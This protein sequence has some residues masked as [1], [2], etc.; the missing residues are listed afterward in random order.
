[1]LSPKEK[2][3]AITWKCDQLGMT[4]G[5]FVNQCTEAEMRQV[6]WEYET[7]LQE[8][9]RREIAWTHKEKKTKDTVDVT[10]DI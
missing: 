10:D 3:N 2:I 5:R 9:Q 4:Y 8:R 6:Y 7:L 1:M